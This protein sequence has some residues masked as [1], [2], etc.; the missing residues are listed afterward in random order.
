MAD[1][2]ETFISYL[3]QQAE[4]SMPP[5]YFSAPYR[6]AVAAPPLL[7]NQPA[8]VHAAPI[9]PQVNQMQ[10]APVVLPVVARE[11]LV[12]R[13]QQS[14]KRSAL[15]SLYE[16]QNKCT[17]CAISS[18]RKKFVFGSGNANAAIMIIGEM[19]S[20][21]DESSGIPFSG[22]AGELLTKMLT[23]IAIDRK[24]DAF[25]TT[26]LKC[27]TPAQREATVAEYTA[28]SAVCKEQI[29]I[30]SPKA[31]L[32]LGRLPALT[33]LNKTEP[34]TRMRGHIFEYQGIPV[35]VTYHPQALLKNSSLKRP[36]WEDLQKFQQV[37]KE[38]GINATT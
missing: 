23:A 33:L 8:A 32:F 37:C 25:I 21:E 36:A 7:G 3:H 13:V 5:L 17:A 10:S 19:P 35:C 18:R 24:T 15:I 29:A 26:V 1:A 27:R 14:D 12:N 9:F 30:V 2:L 31:L 16:T 28:C 34:I 4:L 38:H 20:E 6:A 11:P 22:E